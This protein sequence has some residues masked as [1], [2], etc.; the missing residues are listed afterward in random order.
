VASVIS[1]PER[2]KSHEGFMWQVADLLRGN[3]RSEKSR[4]A[5]TVSGRFRRVL[6][7]TLLLALVL[8]G[9][10]PSTLTAPPAQE[11]DFTIT[12]VGHTA[13]P[14]TLNAYQDDTLKITIVVDRKE[15]VHL[16]GYDK[17]FA[18]APGRPATLTFKADRTGLFEYAIEA[19]AQHLGILNVHNRR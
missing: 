17:S 15:R 3:H 18:A 16:S 9:C 19:T 7:P 14:S 10:S 12:V 8:A 11:R 6:F 4:R 13:T 1:T 5:D 2:I